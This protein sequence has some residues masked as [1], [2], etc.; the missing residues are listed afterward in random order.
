MEIYED[1]QSPFEMSPDDVNVCDF[2][3]DYQSP[4]EMNPYDV[5]VCDFVDGRVYDPENGEGWRIQYWEAKKQYRQ[6]LKEVRKR[7]G[8]KDFRRNVRP[9]Y[10]QIEDDDGNVYVVQKFIQN[11]S[12]KSLPDIVRKPNSSAPH[13]LLPQSR[14]KGIRIGDEEFRPKMF[15][16]KMGKMVHQLRNSLGLSQTDLAKKINVNANLIR[17]IEKGG[18]I[19]FNSEDIMVKSLAKSL[20]VPSIQYCE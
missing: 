11:Q 16:E 8:Y 1:Y 3:E 19:T 7:K 14:D 12:P 4:F 10:M 20:N 15:T 5:N 2:V 17:D 9:T 13:V 18:L 6:W